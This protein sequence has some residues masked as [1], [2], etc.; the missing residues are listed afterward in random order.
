MS[1]KQAD[2]LV[3]SAPKDLQLS[4]GAL[5]RVLLNDAGPGLQ[6]ELNL[7][8]RNGINFGG[9]ATTSGHGLPCK[10]VFHGALPKWGTSSPDP[11][12]VNICSFR[13][14]SLSV[15]LSALLPCHKTPTSSLQ[16][17]SQFVS[18]CLEAANFNS[19]GSI[20]FPTLGIGALGY[21]VKS[22][23]KEMID[24]IKRFAAKH[25][26]YLTDISIVV[27]GGSSDCGT[28]HSVCI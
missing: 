23:V 13:N 15:F 18:G 26:T 25:Q 24:S 9:L 6:Q 2:V 3:H 21:P 4:S 5:S 12:T 8:A 10:F 14:S 16:C 17:L 7:V 27:Y 20:A 28:V 22:A 1:T 19:L 11:L